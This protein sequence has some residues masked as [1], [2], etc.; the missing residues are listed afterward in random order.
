M[1]RQK[2]SSFEDYY[3]AYTRRRKDLLSVQPVQAR[4]GYQYTVSTTWNLSVGSTRE[5]AQVTRGPSKESH[6]NASNALDL[7][8]SSG[9]VISTGYPKTFSRQRGGSHLYDKQNPCGGRDM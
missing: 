9:S 1:I 6:V 2:L 5:I 4:A 3:G 8:N 7:L